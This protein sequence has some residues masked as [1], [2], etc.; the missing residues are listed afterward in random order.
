M[1]NVMI[2]CVLYLSG[3]GEGQLCPH[4]DT[5]LTFSIL[6]NS[7]SVFVCASNQLSASVLG[8]IWVTSRFSYAWGYY[9]GGK[10]EIK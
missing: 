5:L 4:L 9:T 1:S 8:V 10:T 2:L 3:F 6:S 7:H